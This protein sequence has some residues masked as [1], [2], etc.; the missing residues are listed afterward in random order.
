MVDMRREFE[1][2][3]EASPYDLETRKIFAD[4][5][6]EFG[7]DSDA[8]LAVEQREWT[9]EK[10]GAIEWITEFA[11]YLTKEAQEE[12]RSPGFKITY[13]ELMETASKHSES[14]EWDD[15]ITLPYI[16]PDRVY[17][18]M[19]EFWKNYELATGKKAKNTSGF[20]G[21]SC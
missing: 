10:Q 11:E 19:K 8:D 2:A 6:D 13:S 18:D 16:T 4:W 20:I 5:L 1:R 9:V 3:I 7:S 14:G 12:W 17:T 21:C 15:W